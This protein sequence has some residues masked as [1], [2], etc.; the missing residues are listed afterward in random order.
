MLYSC[1][2]VQ[3]KC[4]KCNK[5]YYH[6]INNQDFMLIKKV[7]ESQCDIISYMS[8]N[9][10]KNNYLNNKHTSYKTLDIILPF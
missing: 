6:K 9:N 8:T 2:F 5:V 10:Q 7:P 4:C 1:N 3:R